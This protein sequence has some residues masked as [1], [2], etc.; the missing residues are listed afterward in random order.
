MPTLSALLFFVGLQHIGQA[1]PPQPT[2]ATV[3]ALEKTFNSALLDRDE[4]KFGPLLAED[5]VHVGFEGQIG[6]KKEYMAFF[7][8]GAWRYLKYQ[9]SN[10]TVKLLGSTAVVT[11]RVDRIIRIN[12]TETTGAFAFTHVWS[13]S[14][15]SWQVTSSH[16]TSVPNPSPAATP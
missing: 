2:A 5:L 6:G 8:S 9:S 14:G 15:S 1:P 7:R 10:I 3:L 16:V 11:G 12:E 13:H 4:F